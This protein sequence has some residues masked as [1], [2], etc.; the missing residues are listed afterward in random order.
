MAAYELRIKKEAEKEITALPKGDLQ[1]VVQ[2]IRH[3]AEDP[4]PHGGE[5]LKGEGGYV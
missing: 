2:K 3:L 4:R 5:K 1:K